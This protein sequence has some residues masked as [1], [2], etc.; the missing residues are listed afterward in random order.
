MNVRARPFHRLFATAQAMLIQWPVVFSFL[1]QHALLLNSRQGSFSVGTTP[2]PEPG[3]NE[4]L[5][6]VEA[7]ALN[8]V[9]WKIQAYGV[10]VETYPAVLGSDIAGVVEQVGLNVTSFEPGDRV[11]TQGV[12]GMN[13]RSGFQQYTLGYEELTA[14]IPGWMAFEEA[15]TIPLGLATAS[16]GMYNVH[17]T[18]TSAGLLPPWEPNGRDRY[19]GKPFV[20]LGGSSSVGHYVIQLAKL[21]GFSP[22]ITTASLYNAP[23][24]LALGATHVFDRHLSPSALRSTI[25]DITNGPIGTI[26]DAVSIYET[27]NLAYDLLAPGG[28]LV[29]VLKDNVEKD[30]KSADRRVVNVDASIS[31]A[32]NRETGV[33]L[34]AALST[35]LANEEIQPHHVEVLPDGLRGIPEGLKRLQAGVSNVKLVAQPQLEGRWK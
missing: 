35:L 22:I 33:S 32:H 16:L 26:Y 31:Y 29:L 12:I 34:Y 11:I 15:A 28:C 24:L 5:I 9:D 21:S 2:V 23:S 14:Q 17:S 10:V 19:T 8:P 6:R 18:D 30:K 25:A 13:D 1:Q 3:P 27:Q 4:V 20:V 7:A